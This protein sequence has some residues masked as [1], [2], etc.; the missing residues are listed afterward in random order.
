MSTITKQPMSTQTR[1]YLRFAAMIATS[2]AVM[3]VLMYL[4]TYQ[5]SHIRWSETRFYMAFVMGAAMAVVML[6]FML[7]MYGK[8]KSTWPST[9]APSWC[10]AWRC[11]WCAAR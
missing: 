10:S 2:T 6:S 1:Q 5:A 3:F 9:P 8:R 11:G 7:G 4:N